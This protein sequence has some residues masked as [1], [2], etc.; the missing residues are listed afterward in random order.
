MLQQVHSQHA[1]HADKR[2]THAAVAEVMRLNERNQRRSRHHLLHLAQE[3]LALRLALPTRV[4]Q[5]GKADL[6]RASIVFGA[7]GLRHSA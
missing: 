6:L 1:G 3:R 5:A 4:L 2:A 7:S